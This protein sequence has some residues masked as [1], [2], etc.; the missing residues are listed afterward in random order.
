[1]CA[2]VC[3][4]QIVKKRTKKFARHFSNR[5]MR[6]KNSSWRKPKG[7][8]SSM[9]RRFKGSLP[10]ANVS[11]PPSACV[12]VWVHAG[13]PKTGCAP[14]AGGMSD[15]GSA[16]ARVC[17]RRELVF[18]TVSLCGVSLPCPP[19]GVVQVGYGSDKKTR[20][21]LPNGF[22]KFLVS[23]VDDLELLLMHNRKYCAEIAHNVSSKKRAEIVERASQLN[24]KVTNANA[25]LREEEDA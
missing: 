11:L 21:L 15:L 13:L 6:I 1:M 12:Y 5:F 17:T 4:E 14:C 20:N 16:G 19:P 9:R 7:I 3:G 22:Y 8:D 24:I 10:M 18:T 25:K 23:N 2:R